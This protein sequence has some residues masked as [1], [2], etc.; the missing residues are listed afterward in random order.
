MPLPGGRRSPIEQLVNVRLDDIIYWI[1][2]TQP[3]IFAPLDRYLQTLQVQFE[4][5]R[6]AFQAGQA[7]AE[8]HF[9]R[10]VRNHSAT[11]RI[12]LPGAR[13]DEFAEWIY[14]QPDYPTVIYW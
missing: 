5:D 12:Q 14:G 2:Q 9:A 10:V 4:A 3:A 13:E 6:R 1:Y 11:H 8:E 7:P